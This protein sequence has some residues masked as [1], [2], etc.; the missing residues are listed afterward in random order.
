MGWSHPQVLADDPVEEDFRHVLMLASEELLEW[1]W[2]D[3]R[4]IYFSMR[5]N[6]LAARRFDHCAITDG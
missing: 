2:A 3:G 4:Q 5:S 6:D 1:C